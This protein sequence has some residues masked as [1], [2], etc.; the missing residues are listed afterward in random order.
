[1]GKLQGTKSERRAARVPSAADLATPRRRRVALWGL[2]VVGLLVIV[3]GA[4][5]ALA[6]QAAPRIYG[7]QVVQV[8][9]HDP[10][11]YC[12]GLVFADGQLYEGT[13]RYGESTLRR[14]ALE[15]GQPVLTQPLDRSLFGE[16]ITVWN[17]QIIQLTWRGGVGIV[18]DQQTFRELRRFR[19]PGEGWGLTHDGRQLIM[20]DGSATLRFLDPNTYQVVRRLLV[21]SQGRR[22]DQLNELEYV[23]GEIWA[24]IWYKDHVARI[25]PKTGSVLGWIDFRNLWPERPDREAVLNGIAYDATNGRLFITGKNWPKLFEVRIT[26][27]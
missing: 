10:Q 6:P 5:W 3:T 24:N 2:V 11:A 16:G 26:G 7:Y 15:T 20:S 25:S 22:V 9:P 19:Y 27:P 4:L 8:Y 21:S 18:Y 12:Q 1:M 13:G 23:Q 17:G 14:V